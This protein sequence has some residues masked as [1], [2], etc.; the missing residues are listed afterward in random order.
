MSR[1]KGI[2]YYKA[3]ST[4]LRLNCI[5]MLELMLP[6]VGRNEDDWRNFLMSARSRRARDLVLKYMIK[7]KVQVILQQSD[8]IFKI[9]YG[10]AN[11]F[12]SSISIHDW[13]S[14]LHQYFMGCVDCAE[15]VVYIAHR[16]VP[17]IEILEIL[18]NH[19]TH[20]DIIRRLNGILPEV[21]NVVYTL[22]ECVGIYIPGESKEFDIFHIRLDMIVR[23]FN[24]NKPNSTWIGLD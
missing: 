15:S 17:D 9:K 12:G 1:T 19:I 11:T 5:D 24:L 22:R 3:I 13:T 10:E 8:R 18:E 7:R 23:R 14:A 21:N 6:H 16:L 4:M 20:Y 2:I